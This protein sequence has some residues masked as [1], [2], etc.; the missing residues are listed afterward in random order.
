M[1]FTALRIPGA[2]RVEPVAAEDERGYFA[3]TW[4]A[5]EFAAH[6]LCTH[7]AQTSISFNIRKGTLRGL[8]FQCAP[9]REAKLVRCTR[10]AIYDVLLDV[11]PCSATYGEWLAEELTEENSLQLYIPEGVAHGFQ[12]LRP[13][14]EVLY[15]ISEPHQAGFARGVR[16]D[17]PAFGVRWPDDMRTMAERDRQYPEFVR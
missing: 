11:R 1:Q 15:M 6:G 7:F 5:D 14:S 12:T 2:Y 3:R 10:G 4:C 9:H 16:W 8:H 13:D 17:D